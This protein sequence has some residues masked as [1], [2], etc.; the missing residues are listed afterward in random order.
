MRYRVIIIRPCLNEECAKPR[1]WGRVLG[2]GSSYRNFSVFCVTLNATLNLLYWVIQD[3]HGGSFRPELGVRPAAMVKGGPGFTPL[4]AF[5]GGNGD[6]LWWADGNESI[7]RPCRRHGHLCVPG[8]AFCPSVTLPRSRRSGNAKRK[9][10]GV[11]SQN[12]S[13]PS[14]VASIAG[15]P[16]RISPP[17]R[18]AFAF[19]AP[20]RAEVAIKP[21]RKRCA[22]VS[23]LAT[24][25]HPPIHAARSRQDRQARRLAGWTAKISLLQ[26]RCSLRDQAKALAT[27]PPATKPATSSA[28]RAQWPASRFT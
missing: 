24:V 19:A 4:G 5:V 17:S 12:W 22:F 21:W 11:A 10:A 27:A 14:A 7:W 15:P 18:A 20:M 6:L 26:T 28:N 13:K 2:C 9:P 16:W 3:P 8:S 25:E 23:G 1:P